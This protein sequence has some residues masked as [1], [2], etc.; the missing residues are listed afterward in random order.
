MKNLFNVIAALTL[1]VAVTVFA[2]PVNNFTAKNNYAGPVGVVRL[3]TAAGPVYMNVPSQG[4]FTMPVSDPVNSVV[5]NNYIIFQGQIG[6]ATLDN[7]AKVKVSWEGPN[8]III[9]PEENN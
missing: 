8:V 9:N 3:N 5:I 7:G 6:T 1:F 2:S 4:E